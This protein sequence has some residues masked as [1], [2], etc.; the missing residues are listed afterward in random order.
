[1]CMSCMCTYSHMYGLMYVCG[2]RWQL[3]M[4]V[5]NLTWSFSK[6]VHFEGSSIELI[7]ITRMLWE[8]LMSASWGWNYRKNTHSPNIYRGSR[9]LFSHLHSKLFS[10][11]AVDPAWMRC[12]ISVCFVLL[13]N[14]H[15]WWWR[16][17][18]LE[19]VCSSKTFV[20]FLLFITLPWKRKCCLLGWWASCLCLPFTSY[21]L[22]ELPEV[23]I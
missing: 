20:W 1:M 9:I 5:G 17:T 23:F 3:S 14:Q 21:N 13:F 22:G 12:F 16:F 8:F 10:S 15:V 18:S 4:A 2:Y 7:S 19:F 11:W 6:F